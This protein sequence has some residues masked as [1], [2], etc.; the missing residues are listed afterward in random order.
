M[1]HLDESSFRII[2]MVFMVA[3]LFPLSLIGANFILRRDKRTKNDVRW[4][5]R[6]YLTTVHFAILYE[7]HE[8]VM[9]LASIAFTYGPLKSDGNWDGFFKNQISWILLVLALAPLCVWVFIKTPFAE[10]MKEA[11]K[12]WWRTYQNDSPAVLLYAFGFVGFANTGVSSVWSMVGLWNRAAQYFGVSGN[13]NMRSGQ[14]YGSIFIILL[15]L[16]IT[17]MGLLGKFAIWK[18]IKNSFFP[19]FCFAA[20][21]F[22]INCVRGILNYTMIQRGAM[23]PVSMFWFWWN[24]EILGC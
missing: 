19:Y 21:S 13:V 1:N 4:I 24:D 10:K 8:L 5:K 12:R 7:M 22:S 20:M 18:R 14:F 16:L 17:T 11:L 3:I 23:K 6:L 9:R 2:D 15:S